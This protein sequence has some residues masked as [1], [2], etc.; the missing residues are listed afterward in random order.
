MAGGFFPNSRDFF[1]SGRPVDGTFHYVG[2]CFTVVTMVFFAGIRY[3]NIIVT[4]LAGTTDVD[5]SAL[6]QLFNYHNYR[7]RTLWDIDI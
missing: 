6:V 4:E 2:G 5:L 3:Q 7:E 1:K